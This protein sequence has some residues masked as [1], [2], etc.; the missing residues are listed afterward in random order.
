MSFWQ[1][2]KKRKVIRVGVA[3]I[4]VAWLLVQVADTFFPALNLPEWTITLVAG[5]VILGFPLSLLLAW[6]YDLTPHEAVPDQAQVQQAPSSGSDSKLNYAIFGL[7]LLLVSLFMVDRFFVSSDSD[8]GATVGTSGPEQS[9]VLAGV[10]PL[11]NSVALAY[12]VA[13]I[14]FDGPLIALSPNGRWLAFVG[15]S[16]DESHLFLRD[17]SAFDE[18]VKVAGTQGTIHAFFSPNGQSIGFVTDDKLKSVSLDGQEVRTIAAV[19]APVRGNWL[20]EDTI[21]LIDEQGNGISRIE[22]STGVKEPLIFTVIH[23]FSRVL[24]GG[25]YAL[26]VRYP[27]SINGDQGAIQLISLEGQPAIDL[28]LSGY[29]A[30]PLQT[31]HLLFSRNGNLQLVGFDAERLEIVGKPRPVF[32]GLALD[33]VFYNAQFA[34][35]KSGVLA[36]VPGSDNGLGQ[37]VSMDRES[38]MEIITPEIR[39]YGVLDLAFDDETLAVHIGDITDHVLVYDLERKVGRKLPGSDGFGWPQI[40]RKGDI[41]LANLNQ[42]TATVIRIGHLEREAGEQSIDLDGLHGYIADWSADGESLSMHEWENGGRL[43]RLDRTGDTGPQWLEG[44]D[45]DWGAVFSPDGLWLAYSSNQS[46]RYEIW[47]RPADGSGTPRQLSANGGIEAVWCPCGEIYYRRGDDIWATKVNFNDGWEFGAESLAFA[48]SD[49]LDTP[50][51]SFDVSS[52]GKTLYYVKLAESVIND[53]IH[54]ISNFS[55]YAEQGLQ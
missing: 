15:R 25:K 4:V 35:S 18:P 21:F 38:R 42:A 55:E 22:V 14:G 27:P 44:E 28:G 41:A 43:A 3:Y 51:R 50:G 49:F 40:S 31:G 17:L 47:I 19:T 12:G 8:Q 33:S 30:R 53:R 20:S 23:R 9:S 34:V 7:L 48:M 37:I 29:D 5:L 32:N 16:A 45:G 39:K 2:L 26:G 11:P 36:F 13:A 46:G 6:A 52:D 54:V 1:E 10:V 24:G